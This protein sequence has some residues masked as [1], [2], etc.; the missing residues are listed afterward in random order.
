[1]KIF[2]YDSEQLFNRPLEEVF[3]FF[4]DARN[5]ETITPPW[6]KFEIKTKGPVKMDRGT[7]IDYRLRLH[8]IHISWQS[9]IEVW[10]PPVRFVDIQVH[11]PY[12]FWRH[13]HLFVEE[14]GRTHVFDHVKYAVPGGRLVQKLFVGREVERIFEFRRFKLEEILA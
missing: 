10:D 6:L 3:A 14:D 4:S 12:R 9:K 5:L 7:L 1:M 11:G 13:E 8:G 2:C